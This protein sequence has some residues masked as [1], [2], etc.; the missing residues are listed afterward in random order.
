MKQLK[1]GSQNSRLLAHLSRGRTITSMEASRRF[2]V[3]SLQSRLS[4]LRK[5]GHRIDEGEFYTTRQGV[6]V[7][8]YRLLPS[9]RSSG[10]RP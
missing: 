2:G 5:R 6:K 7:K 9:R 4:E 10:R 8:R 1:S 3:V